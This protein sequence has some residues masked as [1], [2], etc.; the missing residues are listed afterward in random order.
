MAVKKTFFLNTNQIQNISYLRSLTN[1]QFS[2][3]IPTQ[4][5]DLTNLLGL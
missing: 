2:G 3:T 4:L 5:G 1:N